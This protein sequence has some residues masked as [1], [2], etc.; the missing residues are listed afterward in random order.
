MRDPNRA[1]AFIA[2]I[3]SL[4]I[5]PSLGNKM[6]ESFARADEPAESAPKNQICPLPE[7][8]DIAFMIA[9][10]YCHPFGCK[11]IPAFNIPQERFADLL[12]H[13]DAIEP[14]GKLDRTDL[15]EIATIR[16]N[17]NYGGCSRICIYAAGAKDRLHF[18]VEGRRYVHVGTRWGCDEAMTF[19][20]Y[21]WNLCGADQGN[22]E[23]QTPTGGKAAS[24]RSSAR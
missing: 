8:K 17:L 7:P 13:F 15:A 4:Q 24:G 21:L 9:E 2:V 14:D 23:G 20:G 6:S 11:D 19:Y 1:T 18:S 5:A 12:R 16:I 3:I 10:G 22:D